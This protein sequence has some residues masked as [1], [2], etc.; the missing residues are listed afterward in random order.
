[1]DFQKDI[2]RYPAPQG[3]YVSDDLYNRSQNIATAVYLITGL[4]KDNEPLKWHLRTKALEIVSTTGSFSTVSDRDDFIEKSEYLKRVMREMLSLTDMAAYS[5][6]VSLMNKDILVREAGVFLERIP[7]FEEMIAAT[8]SR[9][10]DFSTF[11]KTLISRTRTDEPKRTSPRVSSEKSQGHKK[12]TP[13]FTVNAKRRDSET[14][15]RKEKILDVIRQKGSVMIKDIAPHIPEC[16][17]KTIQRDL[18]ELVS[19]GAVSKKGER[20]WTLYS[21]ST[22]IVS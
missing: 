7:K 10:L 5:G 8:V 18:I 3:E 1:M 15:V 9:T 17:E 16:S 13:S 19:R 6:M 2:Q 12:D 21:L 4:F 11:K 14:L 20:R 22:P